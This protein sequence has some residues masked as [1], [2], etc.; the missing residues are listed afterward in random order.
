MLSFKGST[1]QKSGS[2]SR[3]KSEQADGHARTTG[4]AS[5]PTLAKGAQSGTMARDQVPDRGT[6]VFKMV[7]R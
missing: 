7:Q 5:P 6:S 4:E 2:P 3:P 1:G